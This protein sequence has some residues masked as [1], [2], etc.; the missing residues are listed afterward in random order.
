VVLLLSLLL[1]NC[2]LIEIGFFDGISGTSGGSA[3]DRFDELSDTFNYFG[4]DRRV[5]VVNESQQN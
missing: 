1:I 3:I 5:V 4:R 2:K